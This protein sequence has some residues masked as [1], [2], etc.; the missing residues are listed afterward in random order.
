VVAVNTGGVCDT[1]IDNETGLLCKINDA[2]EMADKINMLVNNSSLRKSM[3]EKGKQFVAAAFSKEKE[4]ENIRNLYT[5]Y[6][7]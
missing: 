4:I 6:T 1:M 7:N 3:G 5:K 2:A